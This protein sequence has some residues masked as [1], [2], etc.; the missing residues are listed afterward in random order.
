MSLHRGSDRVGLSR[1]RG[2]ELRCGLPLCAIELSLVKDSLKSNCDDG[3]M[4]P[5]VAELRK[6]AIKAVIRVKLTS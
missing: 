5:G 3:K 4:M 6:V 1:G 2:G